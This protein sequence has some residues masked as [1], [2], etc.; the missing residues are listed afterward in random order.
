MATIGNAP[1]FP[2]ESVLPGNLEVTGNATINGTTNS[3]GALTENSNE[4]LNVTNTTHFTFDQWKLTANACGPTSDLLITN[5]ERVHKVGTGMTHS[6]GT[7]SFPST[8]LYKVIAVATIYGAAADNQG[9]LRHWYT[10][11]NSS[12]SATALGYTGGNSDG[13]GGS[14]IWSGTG[15]TGV[16]YDI[17][18]TSL[19]K[20]QFKTFS[21][22]NSGNCLQGTTVNI[23]T[24][25]TFERIGNT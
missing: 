18:D 25:V 5:W 17:T 2:T 10:T 4:V 13:N 9:G 20:L 7:F 12:Y 15:Y 3:V 8:G 1:V 14:D 19:C 21:L 6:S 24:S 22:N 11:D 23:Q 16:Y